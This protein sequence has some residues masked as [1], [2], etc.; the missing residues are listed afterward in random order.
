MS[1]IKGM[2]AV[3]GQPQYSKSFPPHS[4]RGEFSETELVCAN[5]PYKINAFLTSHFDFANVFNHVP[6]K[7]GSGCRSSMKSRVLM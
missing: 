7:F 2:W 4:P 1:N 5:L 3:A 6:E